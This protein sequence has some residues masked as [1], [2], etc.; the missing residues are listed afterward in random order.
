MPCI[1]ASFE[2]QF[3]TSLNMGPK[4]LSVLFKVSLILLGRGGGGR[5]RRTTTVRKSNVAPAK[6]PHVMSQS[7][8][9]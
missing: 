8:D 4:P 9:Q 1:R 2:R 5:R 7:W 6:I 3:T